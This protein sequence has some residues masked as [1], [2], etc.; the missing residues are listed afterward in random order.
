MLD[1]QD[2][3]P[4][5]VADVEDQ[6]HQLVALLRIE[7]G[8]GLVEEQESRLPGERARDLEPALLAV[9]ETRGRLVCVGREPQHREHLER[10][11]LERR[12]V[13]LER[14]CAQHGGGEPGDT[15]RVGRDADVV[16]AGEP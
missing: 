12:L 4:E 3:E 14:R 1:Q 5:L 11:A 10:L 16:E 7:S 8:G 2:R 15:V 6:P 13:E 9:R